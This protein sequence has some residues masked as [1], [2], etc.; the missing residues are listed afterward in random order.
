MHLTEQLGLV[1]GRTPTPGE[2]EIL[3]AFEQLFIEEDFLFLRHGPT[4]TLAS[5]VGATIVT[6]SAADRFAAR[7]LLVM[8]P[9]LALSRTQ[10]KNV[11][12]ATSAE[13]EGDR[14]LLVVERP[15]Q[16][17]FISTEVEL[18]RPYLRDE[19]L[20]VFSDFACRT[21]VALG[22]AVRAGGDDT[23]A[24]L[25]CGGWRERLRF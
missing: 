11:V 10:I 5:D 24:A 18:Q 19:L 12:A 14:K 2:A 22:D 21:D 23:E 7:V 6:V 1:P 8:V 20:G 17:L 4:I 3:N 25:S 9:Q 13:E 16:P 15:E